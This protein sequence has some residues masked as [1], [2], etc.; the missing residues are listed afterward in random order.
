MC[1]KLTH[2]LNLN[3]SAIDL[4]LDLD[5]NYVFLEINPNGQWAW[6]EKR[7]KFPIS[8]T[9]VDMLVKEEI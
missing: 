8:K 7:L 1:V 2:K 4:I 3:Y 6:L 9:I 5:D